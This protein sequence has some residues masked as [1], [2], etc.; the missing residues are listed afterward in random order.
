MEAITRQV[1]DFYEELPFNY[2]SV[3]SRANIIK[4]K[5][6]ISVY[7]QLGNFIEDSSDII[8][9]GSGTGW[10]VNSVAYHYGKAVL[11][12][13]PTEKAVIRAR[14]ISDKLGVNTLAKFEVG[15][16]FDY[17][18]LNQFDLVNSIGVL[19]HTYDCK[20][21]FRSISSWVKNGGYLHIG[22]YHYYGRKPF[23]ELFEGIRQKIDENIEITKD[24]YD[25]AYK[26]YKELNKEIKDK[27]FLLS[28]FRDQVLHPHETQH[29]L[30]EVISWADQCNLQLIETSIN[31]FN[32]IDNIEELYMDEKDYQQLSVRKNLRQKKYFPGFFTCLFRKTIKIEQKV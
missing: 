8:D 11:G 3:S 16:I 30:K 22:L 13:D 7:G 18:V 26:I 10:F 21:A 1:K 23:L 17:R 2:G 31:R 9:V 15:D 29:T 6:L 32:T 19:H 27:E 5:N 14:E 28:W 12:F 25:S 20:L 24:E 4:R